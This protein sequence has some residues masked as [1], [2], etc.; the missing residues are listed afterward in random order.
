MNY[1]LLRAK[2]VFFIMV[3]STGLFNHVILIP[4]LLEAA[5]RDAWL[6]VLASVFP[7]LFFIWM[8]YYI[9]KNTEQEK[10]TN[11]LKN[12]YG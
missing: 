2:E 8:I 10:I 6:S 9:T 4:M 3:L 11:W 5:A 1:N 7:F 12:R